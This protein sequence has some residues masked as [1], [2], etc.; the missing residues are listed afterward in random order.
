MELEKRKLFAKNTIKEQDVNIL[1]G[2]Y[3]NAY[4]DNIN[5]PFDIVA[6]T[7][8]A[9]NMINA[10]F[11][12][13]DVL[14]AVSMQSPNAIGADYA[15]KIEAD[16]KNLPSTLENTRTQKQSLVRTITNEGAE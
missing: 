2:R 6:D 15:Q 4:K 13:K 14:E 5:L 3:Y 16:L 10:G 8:I 9:A 1:Y 7:I 12:V 11:K